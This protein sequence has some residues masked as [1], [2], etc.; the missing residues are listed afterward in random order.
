MGFEVHFLN[1]SF[2]NIHILDVFKSF[3]W[4]DRFW[5]CGD[6]EIITPPLSKTLSKLTDTK[7]LRF[8]ESSHLMVLEHS[9]VHT[10]IEKDDTLIIKGRSLESL[11]DRRIVWSGTTLDG[12]FE[13]KMEELLDDNII[14]PTDTNRT[15]SLFEFA[16]ST[17]PIITALTVDTQ[18]IGEYIYNIFTTLCRNKEIGFKVTLTD[19]KK[20]RVEFYAG[21]D[22]SYGQS[23]EPW[24]VFSPYFDN[25]I[26]SDYIQDSQF[27]KTVVLVAG[28][29]GVGNT[30]INTTASA[31]GGSKTGLDRKEMYIESGITRNSPDGELTDA[32]YLDKLEEKGK[33]E[34][35]N[36]EYVEFFDGLVDTTM[37][38][39]GDEFNMGDILQ[40]SDKHGHESQSRVTE[41]IYSQDKDGIKMYPTFTAVE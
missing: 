11:L 39:Y 20:F 25:L 22:R 30:R 13:T 18:V 41:M 12:N 36:N 6:F 35:R 1:S 37:F 34:L 7:Y 27:E 4:V 33:E 31:P 24:V 38:N 2:V 23:T 28:E 8:E 5:E 32:E 26:S 15:I 16:Y 40:I 3:I 29:Q 9:N 21:V 17:D 14:S 10:E 19:A